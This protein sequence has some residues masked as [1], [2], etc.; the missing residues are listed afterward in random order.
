MKKL[1][2]YLSV[3]ICTLSHAQTATLAKTYS[4]SFSPGGIPINATVYGNRLFTVYSDPM[5][6]TIQKNDLNGTPV[7]TKAYQNLGLSGNGLP[8]INSYNGKIYF[9]GNRS[10]S[11]GTSTI[12]VPYVA[13][14]DTAT[15]NFDFL[16]FYP[17]S[18]PYTRTE[19]ND[20]KIMNNGYLMI[21]GYVTN[22]GAPSPTYG[23]LLSVNLSANASPISSQ[24]LSINNGTFTTINSLVENSNGTLLYSA[25]STN[26]ACVGKALKSNSTLFFSSAHFTGFNL[27]SLAKYGN[28]KRFLFY[29]NDKVY[30][31]DTNLA[32]LPNFTSSIGYSLT[33]ANATTFLN[34]KLYRFTSNTIMQ[35]VDTTFNS[36]NATS[37]DYAATTPSLPSLY[38]PSGTI[39]GNTNNVFMHFAQNQSS[40][41]FFMIK[42]TANGQLNCATVV[43]ASI[44]PFTF[45]NGTT[46]PF[47]SGPYTT[48][49]QNISP[50]GSIV[51]VQHNTSCSILGIN[52]QRLS[53]TMVIK[54]IDKGIYILENEQFISRIALFDVSGRLVK[55]IDT[56]INTTSA[57]LNLSELPL[58]LYVVKFV[59]SEGEGV[60]KLTH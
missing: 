31:I 32:S 8:I 35:V 7:L 9:T 59:S 33:P 53:E 58:G 22:F 23:F 34:N 60:I 24:T 6:I 4:V 50:T 46:I 15:L 11:S 5:G 42:A 45:L 37:Y 40:S 13:Q 48:A 26:G 17:S 43:S 1:F 20:A 30:K 38:I 55:T 44:S 3:F 39:C 51:T 25:N 28:P 18:L 14:I 12:Q 52:A 56:D 29:T 27:H 41:S 49:Q 2:F 54:T 19:V 10:I 21:G 47:N 57:V 36:A 16:A